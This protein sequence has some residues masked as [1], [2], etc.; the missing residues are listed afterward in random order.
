MGYPSLVIA[1]LR[2]TER[3]RARYVSR[4][5]RWMA[6]RFESSFLGGDSA[7][8]Q[9][10]HDH[11][12]DEAIAP[13]AEIGHRVRFQTQGRGWDTLIPPGE[14]RVTDMSDGV[15]MSLSTASSTHKT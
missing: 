7:H 11:I 1:Y 13:D 9:L 8:Q 10:H 3:T 6:Q 2:F 15:H 12:P 4:G 14:H 5:R